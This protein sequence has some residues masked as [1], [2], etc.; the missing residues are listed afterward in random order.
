MA[1]PLVGLGLLTKNPVNGDA[2]AC[3]VV[4][5][6]SLSI[7]CVAAG[8]SFVSIVYVAV[9]AILGTTGLLK[10]ENTGSF[11]VAG[12]LKAGVGRFILILSTGL[13]VGLAVNLTLGVTAALGLGLPP[14]RELGVSRGS[15]FAAAAG[16]TA[17]G[18]FAGAAGLAAAGFCAGGAFLSV[19]DVGATGS[20]TGWAWPR[21]QQQ[22]W[23]C[24]R[25]GRQSPP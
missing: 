15:T 7:A 5:S 22:T 10:K 1:W 16:F 23:A 11:F 21:G 13:T 2:F 9:G 18:C 12:A 25:K 4:I 3:Y 20:G 19:G 8:R 17:S 14:K 6:T 24:R